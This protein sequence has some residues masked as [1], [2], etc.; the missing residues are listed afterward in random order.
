M[1]KKIKSEFQHP[2]KTSL[3]MLEVWIY[4]NSPLFIYIYI[5]DNIYQ[6]LIF[7]DK[8]SSWWPWSYDNST[9]SNIFLTLEV[10][11]CIDKALKV[12]L[13]YKTSTTI[14]QDQMNYMQK[15]SAQLRCPPN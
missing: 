14:I 10:W 4:I 6:F 8:C 5:H 1:D 12:P 3:H 2:T 13:R 9:T 7:L 15:Q 11:I